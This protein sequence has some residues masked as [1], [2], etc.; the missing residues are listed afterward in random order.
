MS[1]NKKVA[2]IIIIGLFLQ[3]CAT[4]SKSTFV[5][6]DPEQLDEWQVEGTISLE[7]ENGVDGAYFRYTNVEGDYELTLHS[8]DPVG[9]PQVVVTGQE[10]LTNESFTSGSDQSKKVLVEIKKNFDLEYLDYWLRGLP[11][12][13]NAELSQGED[14][15]LST[16]REQGWEV[17]FEDYMEIGKYA[18]PEKMVLTREDTIVDIDLVRG[19][20]GFIN[21]PCPDYKAGLD[22]YIDEQSIHGDTIETL[23][24]SS[25]AAP[26]P[27]WIS[28]SGF[29]GQLYK[30]HG[31]IPDPRVGLY[32]PDSM[33]WKLSSPLAPG[34]MGAGR[35]LLLQTAHPWITAA[36]DEHSIVRYDP[37][38]RAR[39]TFVNV[40][41]MVFGSMPQVMASA[42]KVH[43]TH[44]EIEGKIAHPAGAFKKGSEYKANEINSMI[45]VHSTL[46][47]TLVLMYEELESPLTAEEKERFYQETKLFAMLFGI[48]E[49]ALPKDWVEFLAYNRA[50]WNSPQLTVTDNAKKLRDDLF[51][52]P[53]ILMTFPLWIQKVVTAAH[54]PERIREQYGMEYGAW[55][56]FNNAWLMASA[57]MSQWMLPDVMGVSALRHEAN[58]R[59]EGVRVGPYQRMLVRELLG[60]E[61]L[62]N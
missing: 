11:A 37:V 20:T 21:S 24:P 47:E 42:N 16:I 57:R 34:G 10:S 55:E 1:N 62:V 9:T 17:R 56:K 51:T 40:F 32:G 45:W 38:E 5:S 8:D 13:E 58:A 33:M 27:R 43:R 36:I 6:A 52:P 54:M 23:V 25:G 31:K 61:R 30:I 59:L 18:L 41:T 49:D 15:N 3:G 7:G 4:F 35:A 39:R 22:V 19:E 48:P 12:T 26:V 50:M 2:I 60:T 53:N 46:W 28:D 44:I 14:G 29:C